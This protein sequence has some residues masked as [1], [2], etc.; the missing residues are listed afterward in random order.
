VYISTPAMS[1]IGTIMS[2]GDVTAWLILPF[3]IT[4]LGNRP[5]RAA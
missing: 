2:S 4:R 5:A 3:P 1:P